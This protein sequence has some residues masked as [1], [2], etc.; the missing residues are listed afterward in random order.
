MV[1]HHALMGKIALDLILGCVMTYIV[2]RDAKKYD[3]PHKNFWIV[4]TFLIPA[5]AIVYFLYH[6]A[7]KKSVI[8]SKR[9]AIMAARRRRLGIRQKE[10]RAERQKIAEAKGKLTPEEKAKEE[11]QEEAIRARRHEALAQQRKY[12]H[13]MMAKKMK[14]HI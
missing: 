13:E 5:I 1:M 11:A 12:K 3:V 10:L 6:K 14:I 4:G 8:L 9:Q 2:Y 7:L